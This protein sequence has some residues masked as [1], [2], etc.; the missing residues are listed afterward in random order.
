MKLVTMF[1]DL[2]RGKCIS[3]NTYPRLPGVH[4]RDAVQRDKRSKGQ[5]YRLMGWVMASAALHIRWV[6]LPCKIWD[7]QESKKEIMAAKEDDV[8]AD[9]E[10]G[11][12]KVV[13]HRKQVGLAA[14]DRKEGKA[15]TCQG[16]GG[17][18]REREGKH[19]K[20][21]ETI[22]SQKSKS[23]FA[24]SICIARY[25]WYIPVRRI[26]DRRTAR[27]RVVPSKID[28]RRSISAVSNRFRSST[29]D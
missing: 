28:R 21:E 26:T 14:C 17:G 7:P 24:I 4:C 13:T 5:P 18:E 11:M 20:K 23:R 12:E 27:Y 2:D 3:L 10:A 19:R 1:A 15:V 6:G 8:D 22:V 25:G 16:R 9:D 29:A